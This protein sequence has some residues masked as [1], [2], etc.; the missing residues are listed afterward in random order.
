ML[1]TGVV[2]FALNCVESPTSAT[3]T[4]TDDYGIGRTDLQTGSAIDAI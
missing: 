3:P 1:S 2:Y 4:E